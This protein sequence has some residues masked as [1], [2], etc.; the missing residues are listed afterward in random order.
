MIVLWCILAARLAWN[1]AEDV[2]IVLGRQ[3]MAPFLRIKQRV[4]VEGGRCGR[5]G[6]YQNIKYG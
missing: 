5:V 6:A 1:E 2:Q 3:N 4:S